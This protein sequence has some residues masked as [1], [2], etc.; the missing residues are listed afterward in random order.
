MLTEALGP[1]LSKTDPIVIIS[2][3]KY[4]HPSKQPSTTKTNAAGSN[5]DEQPVSLFKSRKMA[6]LQTPKIMQQTLPR[7]RTMRQVEKA[8]LLTWTSTC[9]NRLHSA[10]KR[11]R[12]F[13]HTRSRSHAHNP[14]SDLLDHNSHRPKQIHRPNAAGQ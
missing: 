8:R 3:H 9:A 2:P 1:A 10:S 11:G 5:S 13:E 12:S 14:P 4:L 6:D 7:S